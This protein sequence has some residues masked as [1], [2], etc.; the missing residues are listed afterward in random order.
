MRDRTGV[1]L[2]SKPA[3]AKRHTT[4]VCGTHIDRN[5]SM[6]REDRGEMWCVAAHA[7][8]RL[9]RTCSPPHRLPPTA[10]SRRSPSGLFVLLSLS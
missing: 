6:W 5:T 8:R 10:L 7:P 2:E 1:R 4:Y 3:L 9:P